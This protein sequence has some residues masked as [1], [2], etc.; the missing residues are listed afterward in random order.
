VPASGCTR[1]NCCRWCCAWST[2]PAWL[3]CR[4]GQCGLLV[5]RSIAAELQRQPSLARWWSSCRAWPAR[6]GV[7][8]HQAELLPLVLRLVE[9][10]GDRGRAAAAAVAGPVVVELPGL[11]SA[12]RRRAAPAGAGLL[13]VELPGLASACRRRAAPG[14][15]AAGRAGGELLAVAT[16]WASC[17]ALDRCRVAARGRAS[18]CGGSRS[19]APGRRCRCR[20]AG[21][22]RQAAELQVVELLP[23]VLHMVELRG[24]GG[25]AA[26]GRRRLGDGRA[27][28]LGQLG[29]AASCTRPSSC[30]PCR[31]RDAG[32]GELA[33]LDRAAGRC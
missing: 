11:A 21:Q 33:T 15:T 30:R 13:A 24:D 4:P 6:A 27:A 10:R 12:C 23:L 7:E 19:S 2:L 32:H 26:A 20:V 5:V 28:G 29:P 25:R 16:R 18:P 1:P 8:L 9:L 14:R 3:S 22:G 31:C 17:S